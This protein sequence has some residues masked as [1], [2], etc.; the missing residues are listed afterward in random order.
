MSVASACHFQPVAPP[1]S[2]SLMD[3][4]SNSLANRTSPL[5]VS[6][7][8]SH[9]RV[10]VKMQ[11]PSRMSPPKAVL[12]FLF[13]GSKSHALGW[14]SR[15][16]LPSHLCPYS[17][18]SHADSLLVSEY[19]DYIPFSQPSLVPPTVW[20]T[21]PAVLKSSFAFSPSETCCGPCPSSIAIP[22][23]FVRDAGPRSCPRPAAS[24]PVCHPGPC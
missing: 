8:S 17:G 22:Q 14:S 12:C 18:F 5:S 15:P 7:T 19:N 16:L 13:Q 3:C 1:V 20:N 9:C 23:E 4:H 6:S 11:V 2:C 10:L 21:L 24:E